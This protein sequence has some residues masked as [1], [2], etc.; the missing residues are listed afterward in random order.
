MGGR[1]TTRSVDDRVNIYGKA[2][3]GVIDHNCTGATERA[4]KNSNTKACRIA[5][6]LLFRRRKEAPRRSG[7]SRL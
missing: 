3:A 2:T 6:Q 4:Q 7:C 1:H 5:L